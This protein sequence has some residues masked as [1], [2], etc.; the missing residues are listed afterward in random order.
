[1]PRKRWPIGLAAV[2]LVALAI[3]L[4][5]A[6]VSFRTIE[7]SVPG[8][9]PV[10]G[11]AVTARSYLVGTSTGVFASD[12]GVRWSRLSEFSGGALVAQ[13]SGEVLVL[14]GGDLYRGEGLS[15]LSVVASGLPEATALAGDASGRAWLSGEG[16]LLVVERDGSRRSVEYEQGPEGVVALS[17]TEE[18]PVRLY[19]GGISSGLWV[20][21]DGGHTWEQVLQTPVRAVASNGDRRFIGTAGGVL[22]STPVQ[23]WEFTD[24]RLSVE[25]LARADGEFAAV[26]ADRLVYRSADG[27]EWEAVA[28]AP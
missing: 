23:P 25:A 9:G 27:I 26:T 2:L 3:S 7:G 13:A 6:L 15:G 14:T 8:R 16:Q 17:V 19:A 24:L 21:Q 28:A 10:L 1:M 18:N 4:G 22:H 20:S 12:D 11:L 5:V